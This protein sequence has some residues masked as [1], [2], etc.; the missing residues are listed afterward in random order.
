MDLSIVRV[1]FLVGF[2]VAAPLGPIG[3]LV[4][5]RSLREGRARGFFTGLGA[6]AA[7]AV[8]ALLG[9]MGTSLAARF[10][11][12]SAWL[13]IAGGAFLV[14]LG[15]RAWRG[16]HDVAAAEASPSRTGHARA[17]FSTFALTLTNPATIFSFAAVS[18]G[19]G[20]G[21][22]TASTP[23][24]AAL[25]AASVLAGSAAWW[26][27]LSIGV[28]LLRG[29]LGSRSMRAIRVGSGAVLAGFGAIVLVRAL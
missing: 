10:V 18:A 21:T 5:E 27:G 8:F 13:Q 9:A 17:F 14:W 7:D 29:R 16:R 25:L 20:L 3:V 6:A 11:A 24:A 26:L 23:A 2:A 12:Q 15:A 4:I 1:G 28:A 19:L 22:G